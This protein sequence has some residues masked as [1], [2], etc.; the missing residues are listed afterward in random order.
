MVV[1]F[2][3]PAHG[4]KRGDAQDAVAS[5]LY[6]STN[7]TEQL[8]QPRACAG[9]GGPQ[10]QRLHLD[11]PVRREHVQG[12]GAPTREPRAADRA[13]RAADRAVRA[14][15]PAERVAH[16]VQQQQQ[17]GEQQ[18]QLQHARYTL[19]LGA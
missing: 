15:M 18:Q 14:A 3:E 6:L 2:R 16:R 4:R 13:A 9:R 5:S 11:A 12:G 8:H 17:Q 19:I 10:L 7:A 1:N